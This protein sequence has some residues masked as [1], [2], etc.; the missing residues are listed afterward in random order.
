MNVIES[1]AKMINDKMVGMIN[2]TTWRRNNTVDEEARMIND[3]LKISTIMTILYLFNDEIIVNE[4]NGT[5]WE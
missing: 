5:N 3:S 4:S 1:N 2:W